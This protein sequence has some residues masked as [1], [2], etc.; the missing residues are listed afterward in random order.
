MRRRR[1]PDRLRG[2]PLAVLGLVALLGTACS[3][4]GGGGDDPAAFCEQVERL[5]AHVQAAAGAPESVE[6]LPEARAGAERIA[7]D[8]RR[9]R[10]SAPEEIVDDVERLTEATGALADDLRSFYQDLI[11]DPGRAADPEFLAGFEPVTE[12][13]RQEIEDAGSRIRPWLTTHCDFAVEEPAPGEQ[14]A[15]SRPA[16][17]LT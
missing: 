3:G 9:L 2:G 6:E 8:A 16:L 13:R 7:E 11:D 1:R 5:A 4:G 15:A 10:E 17:G 14:G 12:E